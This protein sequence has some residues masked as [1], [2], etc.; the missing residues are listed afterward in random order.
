MTTAALIF[1]LLSTASWARVCP[2][3]DFKA[4]LAALNKSYKM[5]QGKNFR[6]VYDDI[7]ATNSKFRCTKITVMG[8]PQQTMTEIRADKPKSNLFLV[9]HDD[10]KYI[11]FFD[12]KAG[13]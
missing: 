4:C 6:A 12:A 2:N 5:D 1:T 9:T 7:C 8:D 3:N 11:Y 10:G 13:K